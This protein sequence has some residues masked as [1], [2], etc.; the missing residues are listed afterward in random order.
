MVALSCCTMAI[1]AIRQDIGLSATAPPPMAEDAVIAAEQPLAIVAPA[2]GAPAQVAGLT[3]PLPAPKGPSAKAAMDPAN[4]SSQAAMFG[5]LVEEVGDDL[6]AQQRGGFSIDGLDITLGAQ[7]ETFIDGQLS[8][9]TTVNWTAT[10]A[11]TTQTVSGLLTP[12]SAAELQAG[13]LNTGQISMNVG[14]ASVYLANGG[15][16]AVIHNTD[17]G[18]QNV[19]I[20]TA[21]NTSIKTQVTAT[22]DLSGYSAFKENFLGGALATSLGQAMGAA[23]LNTIMN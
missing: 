19:L 3:V 20:N 8:L 22:I 9:I 12:A 17:S 14:D 4:A 5:G 13:L 1:L 6:L 7:I 16:T 11:T 10:S 15:Q 2:F 23:T 21:S 18:I